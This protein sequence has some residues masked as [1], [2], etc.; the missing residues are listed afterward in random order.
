V[1][2][3]KKDT[4]PLEPF[5]ILCKEK[6]FWQRINML[7]DTIYEVFAPIEARAFTPEEWERGELIGSIE[8][9]IFIFL[10]ESLLTREGCDRH[11]EFHLRRS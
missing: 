10:P 1:G 6:D 11:A 2:S 4:R 3:K 8:N 9:S 7:S 5:T